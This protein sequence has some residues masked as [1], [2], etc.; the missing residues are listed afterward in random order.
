MTHQLQTDDSGTEY[1][2]FRGAQSSVTLDEYPVVFEETTRPVGDG[3]IQCHGAYPV[4]GPDGAMTESE[5]EAG[6]EVGLW[7]E[8]AAELAESNP[9]VCYGMACELCDTVCETPDGLESHLSDSHGENKSV[10]A[11]TDYA[12]E[13]PMEGDE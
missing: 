2:Q 10:E 1:V 11:A 13:I 3:E 12:P 8:I 9:L 4:V 6:D 5:A 7:H